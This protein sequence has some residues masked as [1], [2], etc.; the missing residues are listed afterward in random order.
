MTLFFFLLTTVFTANASNDKL[1]L[2]QFLNSVKS[3]NQG[4][5]ASSSG[6]EA[7]KLYGAEAQIVYAPSLFSGAHYN[8]DAKH[9]PMPLFQYDK[10]ISETYQL[11]IQ[12]Q[13]PIGLQGKFYYTLMKTQYKGLTPTNP[14]PFADARPTLELSQS[15]W[16]NDFGRETRAMVEAVKASAKA[17]QHEEEFNKKNQLVQAEIVYWRLALARQNEDLARENLA[18]AQK[19]YEWARRRVRLSL[20]DRSDLLQATSVWQQRKLQL[21]KAQDDLRTVALAF[22]SARGQSG[23]EVLERLDPISK[24]MIDRLKLAPRTG[25][26][27]D[28]LSAQQRTE[29]LKARA[30]MNREKNQPNLEIYGAY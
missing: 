15:L 4:Y 28:V 30:T 9:N 6:E 2:E 29:A 20:A 23:A 13:T 27:P 22:N 19:I 11:G 10:I 24:Q 26:R 17:D 7:A 21:K 14:A 16:R 5:K 8:D 3:E 18:R 25:E 12:Q 1:S